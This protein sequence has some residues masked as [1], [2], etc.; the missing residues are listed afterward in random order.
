M[1]GHH[2]LHHYSGVRVYLQ[3]GSVYIGGQLPVPNQQDRLASVLL[4]FPESDGVL[5]LDIPHHVHLLAQV[6]TETY[7][8]PLQFLALLPLCQEES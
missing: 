7:L 2:W 5:L 1:V 6:I 8:S 4:D 3:Y